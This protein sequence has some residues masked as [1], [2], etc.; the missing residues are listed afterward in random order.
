MARRGPRR[1]DVNGEDGQLSSLD[2]QWV[3]I[4]GAGGGI[5]TAMVEA[6]R[7]AGASVVACDRTAELVEPLEAGHKEIFD[8]TDPAACQ[9]ALGR[10]E[11]TVGLPDVVV[12]NAGHTRAETFEQIDDEAWR[13]ELDVNLTSAWNLTSPLLPKMRVRGRGVFVFTASVNAFAHYGNPAYSAAKAGLVAY[14]RGIA[15]ECGRD[16]IRANVVCPG[17]VRTSAWTHR[18]AKDSGVIERVSRLYPLGRLVEPVEVANAAVFLA[19]PLAS[20][21]TGVALP[22][23]AGLTAGNLP[24]IAQI[25]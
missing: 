19:S 8:L 24:F 3:L 18:V 6:F 25:A 11:A 12:S 10:I 5:G 20:G 2:G 17:S 14:A 16:G 23:D 1:D 9:A 15:T 22:V 21:I 13:R 7:A 4:T